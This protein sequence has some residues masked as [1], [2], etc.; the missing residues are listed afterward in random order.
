MMKHARDCRTVSRLILPGAWM[1][2][3]VLLL[4]LVAMPLTAH[5]RTLHALLVV[6]DTDPSLGTAMEANQTQ[7]EQLLQTINDAGELRLEL[8]TQLSSRNEATVAQIRAWLDAIRPGED[9]VLFVYFSGSGGGDKEGQF[10]SLQDGLCY[11][12]DLAQWVQN[13]GECRLKLLITDACKAPVSLPV[14]ASPRARWLDIADLFH[15]AAGFLHITSA[16]GEEYG[17]A[18]VQNGGFF[19]NALMHALAEGFTSWTE[20]FDAA[21]QETGD[22]FLHASATFSEEMKA[23]LKRKGIESQTPKA[24]ALPDRHGEPPATPD[25]PPAETTLWALTNPETEFTLSMET[26]KTVYHI[27]DY[28]TVA[29]EV[30]D[31][32]YLILLNWDDLGRLT[33]LFPFPD[34]ASKGNRISAGS[35]QIPDLN[36]NFELQMAGPAG[37][38]RLKIL[39]LRRAADSNAIMDFFPPPA[40]SRLWKVLEGQQRVAVEEEILAR[41]HSMNPKDWAEAHRAVELRARKRPKSL[42]IPK[43]KHSEKTGGK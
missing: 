26:G 22:L 12:S 30:T 20:V 17:W 2:C 16:T 15:T 34:T 10:L 27:K 28:L 14:Q 31:D 43:D 4:A 32:A 25:E 9:D 5:T 3:G 23:P 42:I 24:Y 7:V 6:I 1:C 21:R 8:Q 18:D 29:G 36:P 13:A 38:E 19:T 39:A 11:Q 35:Y 40:G 41:L 33:V 37:T